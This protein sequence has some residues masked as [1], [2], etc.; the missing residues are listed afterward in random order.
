MQAWPAQAAT[1]R[2]VEM[3]IK[4][5]P[6]TGKAA[7]EAEVRPIKLKLCVL[8]KSTTPPSRGLQKAHMG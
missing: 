4:D 2:G 7:G 1:R 6:L 3:W 8:Q 5:V